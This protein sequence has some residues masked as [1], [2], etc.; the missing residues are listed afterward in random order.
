MKYYLLFFLICTYNLCIGQYIDGKVI[1]IRNNEKVAFAHVQNINNKKITTCT[2]DGYFKIRANIGDT[3]VIS[4]IGFEW[5]K[6]IIKGY[7]FITIE[8]RSF[9]YNIDEVVIRK[10]VSDEQFI[11]DIINMSPVESNEIQITGIP[12]LKEYTFQNLSVVKRG[13]ITDIYNKFNKH[14]KSDAKAIALTKISYKT[15]IIV[16]KFNREIVNELTNLKDEA[17]T[18]FIAYCNYSDDFLY[19]IAELELYEDIRLKYLQFT[20]QYPN[21]LDSLNTDTIK[22][23]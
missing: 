15:Q 16:H 4:A 2:E 12:D 20:T 19:Q 5:E 17:L 23:S 11:S 9:Y 8:T 3:L 7:E 18:K 21:I 10:R 14:A 1:D 13:A 22:K 6:K